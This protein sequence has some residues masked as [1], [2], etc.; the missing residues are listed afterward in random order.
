MRKEPNAFNM[1]KADAMRMTDEAVLER[2][3]K[4]LIER[5]GEMRNG[6]ILWQATPALRTAQ[7]ATC[8]LAKIQSVGKRAS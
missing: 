5:T 8:M 4:G 1:P 2:E 7:N 3:A 6:K